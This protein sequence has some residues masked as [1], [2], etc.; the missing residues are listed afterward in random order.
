M[1]ELNTEQ[2]LIFQ[3]YKR[4]ENIFVTGPAGSGKSFLIKTI[5]N[6]SV[7]NDYKLQV[8][9]L[10]GC[11]SIL[12]NCKA[13]TLHRF[14]G[15]G[16]ANK[17]IDEVVED[18]FEK[19]YKLKKWYDLK[20]LIIDEVS[21]MSLKIL[22]ILDKM[23][24]K[25][26][27]KPT[28]PFGGLQVIFSGD[29]Y[30]LP[31][32]KSNDA[33]EESSMFCFE[34]PIWNELFPVDNQILL[35]SIFRQD[36]KEFL[37]VLKYVR[38]GRITESTRATL[39]KRVFT[40]EELDKIRKEN[41]VTIISPYKKD[42]DNINAIA[43]KNLSDSVEKKVYNIKYLKGS[44]K[45]DCAVE[46]HV[47]NLLIESNASLKADYEFLSN[48]IMANKTLELKIGT[49]VMCIA[50]ISLES[51]IQLANG[52][53]G[54]VVGFVGGQPEVKF[55]NITE[56]IVVDT[57]VWYSEV[58]KNLAV[59]QIPLIYAWAITI[60]KSQGLTLDAA[61]M[62]IGKNIFEYG[63]TYVAL[64]RVRSLSGLYLSSFDYR[65]ICANPKVKAFYNA[66]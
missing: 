1:G 5:V 55:N 59:S 32:I 19:R 36:E 31:P 47:T 56:P 66:T 43:Y 11:A 37:K 3:K 23:A 28:I 27:R 22:L 2:D 40:E 9:A 13:T 20:C 48:N 8:C 17:S 60:H 63:Q 35:K 30:Q 38:E 51:E 58:N 18:V 54:I 12:L 26:Y 33:D 49:H 62:D 39:E 14:A 41:V 24:R 42:T 21:M 6:D 50:N 44:R 16:L 29:F 57:F 61:I 53:Q 10:T 25:I 7:N 34:H 45:S 52:S 64:S 65:K 4:G 46:S 15:I